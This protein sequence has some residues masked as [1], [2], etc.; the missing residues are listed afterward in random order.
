MRPGRLPV[1][2]GGQK[3]LSLTYLCGLWQLVT[4]AS[5]IEGDVSPGL[6]RLD[7]GASYIE[8]DVSA[9]ACLALV[10]LGV[11]RLLA[12]VCFAMAFLRVY[13]II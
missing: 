4:A 13:S 8:G 9:G 11:G 10:Y 1:G 6:W 3:V 7:A 2:Q 5:Y 12:A